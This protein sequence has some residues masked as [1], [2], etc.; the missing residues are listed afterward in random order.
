VSD[1]EEQGGITLS[2]P[3]KSHAAHIEQSPYQGA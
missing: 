3:T 2:G 1:K